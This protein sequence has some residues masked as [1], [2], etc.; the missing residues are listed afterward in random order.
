MRVCQYV[1][2]ANGE[3]ILQSEGYTARHN[4]LKGIASVVTNAADYT[5][6]EQ[7]EAANGELYFTLKAAN[8]EPIG[9]SETYRSAGARANGI[10][11]VQH[12]AA[13]AEIVDLS[14]PEDAGNTILL[15]MLLEI[16]EPYLFY[17]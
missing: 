5:K 9:V 2:A 17:I 11:S 8:G 4:A 14:F 6:F 10:Y 1:Q 12:N 7:K 13:N 3:I 15:S 16:L